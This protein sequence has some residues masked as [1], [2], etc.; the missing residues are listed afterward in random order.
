LPNF[1]LPLTT[2]RNIWL[3]V[4]V[5]KPGIHP[6]DVQGEF[7]AGDIQEGPNGCTVVMEEHLN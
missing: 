2:K 3:D 7:L 6:E 1:F 5:K 4:E